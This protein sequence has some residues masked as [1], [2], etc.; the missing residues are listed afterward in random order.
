MKFATF[1]MTGT[2]LQYC[3]LS[4]RLCIPSILAFFCT[5]NSPFSFSLV[6]IPDLSFAIRIS[7][8]GTGARSIKK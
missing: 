3:F 2:G 7:F 5:F 1:L 6:M 4:S 8:E